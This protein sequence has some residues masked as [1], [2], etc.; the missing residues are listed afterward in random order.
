MNTSVYIA[1]R[2]LF[3]KKQT[4]AINIIS[5]ISILGV[6]VGSA[7]LIIIL[8]VFN[9]LEKVILSLY[10]NFTPELKIEPRYGKTFDPHSP[11]FEGLGRDKRVVSY[12]QVL[13]E[14]ALIRYGDRQFIGTIKGV[15]SDF[16][17]G[18]TLDSTIQF[19]SFTLKDNGQDFAVV[20][21][22]VQG[23]LGVSLKDQFTL[24]QIFSPKRNA[25]SSTNPM[26]D[27]VFRSIQPSG[28]FGIQEDFNDLIITPIEFTRSLLDEPNMVSSIE[29]N[30]KKG[31]DL[32]AVQEAIIDRIGKNY[33]IRNRKEQNT[34]LYNTIN[35]E[36]WSIFMILTFVL[37]IAIFNIIGSLTMLVIDKRKDIAI[38]TSL[39][40]NKGLIQRIFFFEGMMISVIGCVSG[41]VLGLIVCYVQQQFGFIKMGSTMSVL[42][43]YPVAFKLGDIGLV[44]L[45]VIA[46]ATIASGISSSLSVKRLDEIKQEL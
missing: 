6:L 12:T 25:G 9:G 28:V 46:I 30:Y 2:Y 7:A 42:D 27:F 13:Q 32:N 23:S 19:G 40:A 24:L 17:K 34:E 35:F 20:G 33:T 15:S 43:A 10:S 37:I 41:L 3:S 16:L 22:T 38:L 45:T 36:R 26:N 31:T 5:G 11:Y 39:G 18:R 21:S 4:H 44:F 29:I 1:K 8:S 14:K